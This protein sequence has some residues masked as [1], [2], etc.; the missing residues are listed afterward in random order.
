MTHP[1]YAPGQIWKY[2]TRAGEG[3]SRLTILRIDDEPNAGRIVHVSIKGI[4]IKS[5]ASRDGVADFIAHLPFAETAV[6]RSVTELERSAEP[7]ELPEGYATWRSAFDTGKGGVWTL[8]VAEAIDALETAL[9][10]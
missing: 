1:K 2:A 7:P 8:P 10:G 5:P 3:E 6:D 9:N 4:A